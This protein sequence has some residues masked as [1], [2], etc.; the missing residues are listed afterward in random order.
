MIC[1]YLPFDPIMI[2]SI[3]DF[4]VTLEKRDATDNCITSYIVIKV[5]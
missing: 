2:M 1:R 4:Q 3:L 5:R